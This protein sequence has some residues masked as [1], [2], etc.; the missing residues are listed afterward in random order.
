MPDEHEPTPEPAFWPDG[1][2]ESEVSGAGWVVLS[3]LVMAALGGAV[4]GT[5]RLLR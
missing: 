5:W 2:E 3:G 1:D 4:F